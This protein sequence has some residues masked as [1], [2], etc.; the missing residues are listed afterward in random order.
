MTAKHAKR[1]RRKLNRVLHLHKREEFDPAALQAEC[2]K[3][4]AE[5]QEEERAEKREAGQ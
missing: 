4:L 3:I 1:S 2:V 5:I